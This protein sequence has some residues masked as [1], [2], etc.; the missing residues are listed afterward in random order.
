MR[1]Y[2]IK[3]SPRLKKKAKMVAVKAHPATMLI[4]STPA[5]GK[6]EISRDKDTPPRTV[7]QA[8]RRYSLLTGTAILPDEEST[9]TRKPILGAPPHPRAAP[10]RLA[11]LS[12]RLMITMSADILNADYRILFTTRHA[13]W[14][15]TKAADIFAAAI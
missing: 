5:I 4:A 15:V 12:M 1:V 6:G 10:G 9:N 7:S 2:L 8:S 3:A 14:R 13:L 11:W